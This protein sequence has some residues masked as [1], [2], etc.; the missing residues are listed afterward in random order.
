MPFEQ[1]VF[2]ILGVVA[3][4]AALGLVILKDPVHCALMLVLCFFNMAGVYILLGAEFLA[5]V[6]VMVYG[7][8]IMVLFLF[9]M[10]L[11][12]IRPGPSLNPLRFF[13]TRF[14]PVIA[15]AFLAEIILVIFTTNFTLN[16]GKFTDAN[17]TQ[18]TTMY[19]NVR[20]SVEGFVPL[21]HTDGTALANVNNWA[22]PPFV[23]AGRGPS[24]HTAQFGVELYTTYLFPFIISSVVLLVAAIG[25]IVIAGRNL[26]TTDDTA[27]GITL[28]G[29]PAGSAQEQELRK[30]QFRREASERTVLKK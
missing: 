6:Q 2:I 3:T 11:L 7:G 19:N 12:Q 17:N 8:A 28:A 25:A 18:M 13:Q 30:A 24:G 26:G 4:I 29:V 22:S 14:G 9:V 27:E 16:G 10:M 20:T 1:I 21:R 23:A 15:V 5:A